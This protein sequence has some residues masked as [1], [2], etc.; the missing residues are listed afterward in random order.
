MNTVH[1]PA[2]LFQLQQVDL[3]L[4]RL[5]AEQQSVAQA[6][7]G[8][9]KLRRVRAEYAAAQQQLQ[10]STQE[11]KDAEWTLEN[12]NLRL[13]SQEQRLYSG[14]GVNTKDLDSFQ[15]EVQRLR[16]QQHRQE[17]AVLE[18]MDA[19][20]SATEATQRKQKALQQAEEEWQREYTML[21]QKRDQLDARRQE[22]QAKRNQVSAGISE[23]LL[24]RYEALRRSKQGRAVSKVEQ[25]SC[26]WCRV[27]LTPSE[28]QRVRTNAAELQTC[29]N[30]GRILYY[31][32]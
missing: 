25:N 14:T 12:I 8:D 1:V 23:D 2:L 30:C 20:E 7:Q 21:I 11:Q 22:I 6:L 26:Q 19:T 28:L 29:S 10:A 31:E 9:T 15:Q 3:D 32:R 5:T 24:K 18:T 16:A 27:V 17:E 13:A 4:D